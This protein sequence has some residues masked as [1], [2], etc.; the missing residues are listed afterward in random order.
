MSSRHRHTTLAVILSVVAALG[1]CQP[2]VS[3]LSPVSA[4][5]SDDAWP[6]TNNDTDTDM[7][8]P[9]VHTL[10]SRYLET[11]D[12]ITRDG[13]DGPDRM[14]PLTT[15]SWFSVEQAAFA[16][17]RTERLR[18]VGDTI[19]DSLVIQSVSQS[20]TGVLHVDAIACVDATWVWLVPYDS[21]DP[22]DGLIEWLRGG[23]PDENVSD[24]DYEQWSEYLDAVS[25]EPGHR[26]AIVFW[27]VGDTPSSLALDGTI[28]WEGAHACHIAV[29]D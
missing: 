6:V 14:A 29:I 11:T 4:E 24:D 12:T 2:A 3:P 8:A 13:G 25:P 22:P 9:H 1:A 7:L 28:N 5:L 18:T 10:I 26:E 17:Y 19:F 21:P 20:P 15:S 16:H 23:D 27:L